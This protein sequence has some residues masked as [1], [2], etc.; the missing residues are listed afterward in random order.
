M[1]SYSP[2]SAVNSGRTTK[3]YFIAYSSPIIKVCE[4]WRNR[5]KYDS[6]NDVDDRIED[7]EALFFLF[8]L[9][10]ANV[11]AGRTKGRMDRETDGGMDGQTKWLIEMRGRI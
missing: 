10:F 9:I 4:N 7:I 1:P 6:E 8:L 5:N 2:S 11:A 3:K